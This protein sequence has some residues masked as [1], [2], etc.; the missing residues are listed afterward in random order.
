MN[1]MSNQIMW[2]LLEPVRKCTFSVMRDEYKNVSNEEQLTFCMHW[3]NNE[4][5]VSEKF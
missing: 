2:N 5:E 3:V 4:L 1:S